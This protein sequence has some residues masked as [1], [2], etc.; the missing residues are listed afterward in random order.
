MSSQLELKTK[1][2]LLWKDIERVP[3]EELQ[4]KLLELTQL[5]ARYAS[6]VIGHKPKGATQLPAQL[7]KEI[8]SYQSEMARSGMLH[9]PLFG[10]R[11][12]DL[13]VMQKLMA[14]DLAA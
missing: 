5:F 2:F 13:P 7:Y 1:I 10:S 11:K 14:F 12:R 6:R 9:I 4:E 3:E 8:C